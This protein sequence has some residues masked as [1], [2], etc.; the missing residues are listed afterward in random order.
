MDEIW[1]EEAVGFLGGQAPCSSQ[2]AADP[3]IRAT[4]NRM[5]I[6]ILLLIAVQLGLGLLTL[7]VSLSHLD[8]GNMLLA[9]WAQPIVIF[10]VLGI[11]LL[12][13]AFP[14][15]RLVHIWSTPVGYLAR[16]YQLVRKR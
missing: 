13:L 7:P 16:P 10:R 5:D 2:S 15:S 4:S 14:F 8:G 1:E 11:T 9:D 12:F 3:R 6:F